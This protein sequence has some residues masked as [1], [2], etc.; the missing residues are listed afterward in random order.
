MSAWFLDSELSTCS[1]YCYMCLIHTYYVNIRDKIMGQNYMDDPYP[2]NLVR[3]LGYTVATYKAKD[4][5]SSSSSS[6]F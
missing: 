4:R 1:W 3:I 6:S 5:I 2:Q